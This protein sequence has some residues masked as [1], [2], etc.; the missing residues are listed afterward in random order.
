VAARSLARRAIQLSGGQV[1]DLTLT[2]HPPQSKEAEE[3]DNLMPELQC[4]L[5][6]TGKLCFARATHRGVQRGE[7]PLRFFYPP[8][9][10][11]RGLGR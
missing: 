8:R 5:R 11:A 9:L 4:C 6:I 7:A 10:G 1:G 3:Q 2:G